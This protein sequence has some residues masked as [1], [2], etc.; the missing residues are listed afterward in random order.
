MENPENIYLKNLKTI[1]NIRDIVKEQ[2]VLHLPQMCVIG[3]QSSGKSAL[4]N[5]L[6]GIDF[7]VNSG[8]CTK[9]PIWNL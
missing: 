5:Q 3:D 8:I 1:K 2:S 7:P 9:A 6:T 4:L